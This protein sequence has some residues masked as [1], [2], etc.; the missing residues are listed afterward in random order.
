MLQLLVPPEAWRHML[1]AT[2]R[3]C[4]Y[5]PDPIAKTYMRQYVLH[6]YRAK[7]AV[8]DAKYQELAQ[9]LPMPQSTS[10]VA[11]NTS[12]STSTSIERQIRLRRSG[13]KLL[14]LLEH[15]NEGYKKALERVLML[16]Y[17]RI[18]VKQ[19]KLYS[20][21]LRDTGDA[22]Q[23]NTNKDVEEILAKN[24]GC[25]FNKDWQPPKV[26][27]EVLKAQRNSPYVQVDRSTRFKFNPKLQIPTLNS[28]LKPMPEVRLR[29]LKRQWYNRAKS[30]VLP[31]LDPS[32]WDILVGLLR[33]TVPWRPPVRRQ[34]VPSPLTPP[35]TELSPL[36]SFLLQGAQKG[37]T[38]DPYVDERPH[39]ITRRF[40]VRVWEKIYHRSP[41]RVET[42]QGI[43]YKFPTDRRSPPL[44]LAV[45]S[46]EANCLFDGVDQYGRIVESRTQ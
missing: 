30:S 26:L 1:R 4:T 44:T 13:R 14:R 36:E 22:K 6:R 15:A 31:P 17:G 28:W 40:M 3:E 41:L 33:G 35:P 8:F 43:R 29:N 45:R 38:F 21:L 5:L 19:H 37:V 25:R 2:L 20:A 42:P 12:T 24:C 16:S 11:E 18:G 23:L 32:E 9:N 39:R 7:A 27:V 46:E 10:P 34:K